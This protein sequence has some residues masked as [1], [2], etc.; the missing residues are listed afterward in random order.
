M[1]AA[2]AILTVAAC[3]APGASPTP[4]PT[5]APTETPAAQRID[6]RLT[7]ALTIEPAQMT[8]ARDVPVTFVVT[9][10]G[11]LDHEFYLGDEEMQ[12]E[13][14]LEMADMGGMMG[15]DEEN[16]IA[17][18]PGETKELTYTFEL[19]G[20]WLAGC[21]TNGHYGAG[22]LAEINVTD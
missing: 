2:I 15:H 13:H 20:N 18:D 19:A 10:T 17:V 12:A 14:A 11:V 8:V 9:N 5:A 3:A 22:M 21:H 6:V 1:P 4:T 7:D 16:G